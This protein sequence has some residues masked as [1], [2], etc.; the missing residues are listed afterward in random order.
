MTL[1]WLRGG[2]LPSNAELETQVCAVV[3]SAW[4]HFRAGQVTRAESIVGQTPDATIFVQPSGRTRL[5][6]VSEFIVVALA[7]LMFIIL[8]FKWLYPA[9]LSG[10]KP[11][12][13]TEAQ[14]R[15]FLNDSTPN[16]DP[17]K[18]KFNSPG[19]AL[20]TCLV[21]P[22]TNLFSAE[23][24]RAMRN[25]V[26]GGKG[27][28]SSRQSPGRAD[29][30]FGGP[31]PRHAVAEGWIS[32]VDLNIRPEDAGAN[33]RTNHFRRFSPDNWDYFLTREQSWSWVKSEGYPVLRIGSDGLAQLR[34]VRAVNCLDL[35]DRERLIEQ[36]ASV[37]VLSATPSA[38]QP[39]IHDWRDV[40]GLFFTP[41]YPVLVDTYYSLAALEILAGLNKIDR[42]QCIRGILRLHRGRGFFTSP[43]S[44]GYNEYHIEGDARDTIAAFES[45]R[46]LGALG[47]VKDL[48]R[49]QFRPQRRH[50]AKGQLGW[51]DVEAWVCQQRLDKILRTR[52]EHP[53][54]PVRSLLQE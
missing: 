2:N 49:W 25:E 35:T 36:I 13:V 30:V 10:L 14:V 6:R 48:D 21:L 7:A 28:D 31:L 42:E 47:R 18:F 46:I 34:L 39:P 33:L 26:M 22:P 44:G 11:V 45:L 54:A 27:F 4:A 24:L 41:C 50:V 32:W 19:L 12:S 15:A 5:R 9:A 8:G 20:F 38:G 3:E 40:R 16:P 23:A 17:K 29:G 53:Q 1:H 51:N 52:R 43:D 37:Q